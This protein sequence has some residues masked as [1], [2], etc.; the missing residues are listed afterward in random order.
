MVLDTRTMLCSFPVEFSPKELTT[1]SCLY[2]NMLQ[3]IS[4]QNNLKMFL[5]QVHVVAMHTLKTRYMFNIGLI[6]ADYSVCYI[7]WNYKNKQ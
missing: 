3:F 1:G 7:A 5:R 4:W 2:K 6:I